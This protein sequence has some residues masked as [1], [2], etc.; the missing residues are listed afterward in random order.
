M[1]LASSH[2]RST[3]TPYAPSFDNVALSRRQAHVRYIQAEILL[4]ICQTRGIQLDQRDE[5][6]ASPTE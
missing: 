5:M 4:Y 6:G 2:K 3:G 1:L